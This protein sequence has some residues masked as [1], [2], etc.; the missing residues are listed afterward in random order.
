VSGTTLH[1]PGLHQALTLLASH[2]AD[3]PLATDMTRLAVDAHVAEEL[4]AVADRQGWRLLTV[5]TLTFQHDRR[6]P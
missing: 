5:Q 3:A 2:H 6:S 1:R 4:A